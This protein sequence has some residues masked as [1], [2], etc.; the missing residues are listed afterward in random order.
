MTRKMERLY[1]RI[2]GCIQPAVA[3]SFG[4]SDAA[5]ADHLRA[6][7]RTLRLIN[8]S[9]ES[10]L[11]DFRQQTDGIAAVDMLLLASG[12]DVDGIFRAACLKAREGSVFILEDIH[13]DA[14]VRRLWR[15]VVQ[16]L[17]GVV[18][19]DLYYCGLVCFKSK[20]YKCNYV[21]NF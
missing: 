5:L 11:T 13:R 16:S 9:K 14:T 2:S 19:F 3:V 4:A 20:L 15:E 8:V 21:V 1:M 10:G 7:C 18:T 17:Q 12:K 6:G